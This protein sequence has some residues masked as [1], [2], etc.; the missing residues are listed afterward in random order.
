VWKETDE[1]SETL[2]LKN[3]IYEL[4]KCFVDVLEPK[5]LANL[6]FVF[7][8]F[9]TVALNNEKPL[10][11]PPRSESDR[12]SVQ[13]SFTKIW[14]PQ[15]QSAQRLERNVPAELIGFQKRK[16]RKKRDSERFRLRDESC[17]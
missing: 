17:E 16:Y 13:G 7:G 12:A 1:G 9:Q 15:G 10:F 5:I 2:S 3:R 11:L 6:K 4:L 8:K 14:K